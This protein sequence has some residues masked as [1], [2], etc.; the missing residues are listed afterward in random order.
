MSRLAQVKKHNRKLAMKKTSKKKTPSASKKKAPSPSKKKGKCVCHGY[1]DPKKIQMC[2]K[3]KGRYYIKNL[4]GESRRICDHC[5]KKLTCGTVNPKKMIRYCLSL[6]GSSHGFRGKTVGE[7]INKIK[8]KKGARFKYVNS[9]YSVIYVPEKGMR[10]TEKQMA[11]AAP[12]VK[13]KPISNL[14]LGLKPHKKKK[15][16]SKKKSSKKTKSLTRKKTK[17]WSLATEPRIKSFARRTQKKSLTK[18]T[19]KMARRR[20]GGKAPR[21]RVS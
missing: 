20:T 7:I 17:K 12:G 1:D 9:G 10:P 5:A 2:W 14:G 18:R 13:V 11:A 16:S 4:S 3:T 21:K 15:V 6:G 19:K 8:T